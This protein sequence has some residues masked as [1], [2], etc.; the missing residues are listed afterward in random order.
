M[1]FGYGF[2]LWYIVE[3]YYVY[4]LGFVY[5]VLKEVKLMLVFIDCLMYM[6]GL[7]MGVLL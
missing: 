3:Y 7:G 6:K 5:V 4:V 1:F 2:L